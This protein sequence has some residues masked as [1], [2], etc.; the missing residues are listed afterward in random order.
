[1]A[2]HQVLGSIWLHARGLLGEAEVFDGGIGVLEAGRQ[3]GLGL[4]FIVL[5]E[6]GHGLGEIALG[7]AQPG[8]GHFGGD[9]CEALLLL[10]QG[11]RVLQ[12]AVGLGQLQTAGYVVGGVLHR[13]LGGCVGFD[14][15]LLILCSGVLVGVKLGQVGG[16]FAGARGEGLGFFIGGDGLLVVAGIQV[17]FA[18]LDVGLGLVFLL[19]E[20]EGYACDGDAK[21]GGDGGDCC[22]GCFAF[23]KVDGFLCFLL[24][25]E[26]V[27]QQGAQGPENEGHAHHGQ[28]KVQGAVEQQDQGRQGGV[29][30]QGPGGMAAAF[31]EMQCSLDHQEQPEAGVGEKAQDAG[32]HAGLQEM[33]VGFAGPVEFVLIEVV[34]GVPAG[35]AGAPERVVQHDPP[36]GFAHL[37]ALL[38]TG[39]GAADALGLVDDV[40]GKDDAAPLGQHVLGVVD[41][42]G[43]HQ[44]KGDG[45]EPG[46]HQ[47]VGW[48]QLQA[49]QPAGGHGNEN[50]G[51]DGGQTACH[52][53]QHVFAVIAFDGHRFQIVFAGDEC[54]Q[55]QGG[56][57]VEALPAVVLIAQ[58]A[59]GRQGQ[60][61]QNPG[62]PGAAEQ[63]AGAVEEDPQGQQ[64]LGRQGAVFEE[65]QGQEQAHRRH[66]G[67]GVDVT[68]GGEEFP[69]VGEALGVRQD[70]LEFHGEGGQCHG[71]AAQEQ[72]PEEGGALGGGACQ[73]ADDIVNKDA[74]HHLDG[75]HDGV[76]EMNRFEEAEAVSQQQEADEQL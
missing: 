34:D 37:N 7:Q 46:G 54:G 25:M 40:A 59:A 55:E 57:Q 62:G 27:L 47:A 26:L 23:C 45:Q 18:L 72:H 10:A 61:Q 21:D 36:G 22:A 29:R 50:A 33:V 11:V 3:D 41:V 16:G 44:E 43:A 42:E 30:R 76:F 20:G 58:E 69:D 9:L 60:Q 68:K 66:D 39:I 1:M 24:V 31:D 70:P 19:A 65:A 71:Q 49:F 74:V 28:L 52:E 53:D 12:E 14:F 67:V 13:L 4:M 2:S 63:D 35:A 5:I 32:F 15:I 73:A 17:G 8:G 6:Q 38:Q 48:L 75:G 56:S 51:R 64:Q